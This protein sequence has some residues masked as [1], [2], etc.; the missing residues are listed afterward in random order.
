MHPRN[1][2]AAF[3]GVLLVLASC[4]AP[5]PT[6]QEVNETAPM[7]RGA[8]NVAYIWGGVAL[9]A[10]ANDTENNKPRPT[11]NSRMLALPMVAQFDAWSRYDSLAAPVFLKAERRPVAEHTEANKEEAISYAM[12]RALTSVYPADSQLFADQL[13]AL[14]YDPGYTDLDPTTPAGL[15]NLAAHAVIEARHHDGSNMFGDHPDADTLYGDYTH[16][17]PVNQAT[18]MND[19]DRWQPKYFEEE[20]TG[21]RF[22]PGCLSPH[23]QHVAPLFLDSAA[24]FRPPAPPVMGDP[25]L[26]AEVR[27]VVAMQAGLTNEEKALVE[28]MR[29]GPR[30][31]Q[32][33]GHWLIFARDVSLRDDHTLDDDVK[34]YFVVAST[35]MDCFIACWDAKMHYDNSRPYQQ[36]HHLLGEEDITGWGGPGVGMIAMKGKDWRPYSPANFLC[37]PFPAYPSGH[38]TVSGGCGKALELFTGSDHYGASVTLLPGWLTEPGI[39]QDSVTLRFPTFTETAEMAGRSRVLGGYHIQTDNVE[40]LRLGRRVGELVHARCMDHIEGRAGA[41][42]EPLAATY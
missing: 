19:I 3:S 25:R 12:A 41:P 32:Q 18:R 8:A 11:V 5:E 13:T 1:S 35:A 38:S 36:V 20:T 9:E 40:G 4:S 17:V 22:A 21:R 24:Q 14:G 37:P 15:G 30:S 26:E 28:F 27:E 34:M 10:T 33:A 6:G 7:E 23:W 39:T 16:Y 42:R 2:A 31:V 29:D